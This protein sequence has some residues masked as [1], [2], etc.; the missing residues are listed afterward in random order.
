MINLNDNLESMN[1]NDLTTI[2]IPIPIPTTT[3]TTTT[4]PTT[5][6]NQSSNNLTLNFDDSSSTELSSSEALITCNN[7]LNH[8]NL[9]INSSSSC[10]NSINQ[11]IDLQ[12]ET[13]S[14]S[15]DQFNFSPISLSTNST[16]SPITP[17]FNQLYHHHHHTQN[18]P[19]NHT[20]HH[21][22]NLLSPRKFNYHS[23]CNKSSPTSSPLSIQ[24]LNLPNLSNPF[25]LNQSLSTYHPHQLNCLIPHSNI[26]TTLTTTCQVK[27]NTSITKNQLPLSNLS[28]RRRSPTA[29]DPYSLI[30]PTM[31]NFNSCSRHES[32]SS[33][34]LPSNNNHDDALSSSSS[35]FLIQPSTS[36]QSSSS[37]A[38]NPSKS[39]PFLHSSFKIHHDRSKFFLYNSRKRRSWMDYSLLALILIIVGTVVV[40]S[41][42]N[43]YFGIYPSDVILSSELEVDPIFPN[44]I[45]KIIHQTWKTSQIPERWVPVRSSCA[46]AHPDWDYMLWTDESGRNLIKE[47]YSWFLPIYDGY[48]Y[49]IQRADAVRYF[50][51]HHYGGVYM[52]L[53]IGCLRPM[54]SLLRF[55]MILPQTV[56]V[57][58]SND[59]MFS[60]KGHP[61]MNFVIHR[62]AQFDH[63]YLLNYATVMFST[64]PMA[65]SALLSQ[66]RRSTVLSSTAVMSGFGPIRILPP[67]LYGKNLAAPQPSPGPFFTHY[68]GSS[69]HTEGAGMV[70]WLGKFGMFCLYAAIAIVV[71]YSLFELF[72]RSFILGS[73]DKG[74]VKTGTTWI[75]GLGGVVKTRRAVPFLWK[76]RFSR[77]R[78]SERRTGDTV[79][80]G[81]WIDQINST[82]NQ[83]K[84]LRFTRT[85][86]A[87]RCMQCLSCKSY[88]QVSKGDEDHLP[89]YEPK[90]LHLSSCENKYTSRPDYQE[91]EVEEENW[92]QV[93]S[94]PS[95]Q[96]LTSNPTPFVLPAISTSHENSNCNNIVGNHLGTRTDETSQLP[97][98][99]LNAIYRL[100]ELAG[101]V[102][103]QSSGDE[104]IGNFSVS[105]EAGKLTNTDQVT[106]KVD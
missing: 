77:N 58:I 43:M 46:I 71:L 86:K 13:Y 54:D 28:I 19:Q 29:L 16:N 66:A 92:D 45:P 5:T 33:K 56:P 25:P 30:S 100:A 91:M 99:L 82:S 51:L 2:P 34:F 53:D 90:F 97:S 104:V 39:Q 3:T 67:H 105:L 85:Q 52:D 64:G 50:I 79:L 65:L 102:G 36:L 35:S 7:N 76:R 84:P 10:F 61:F 48:P 44:R 83:I 15:L 37:S 31:N 40:L 1:L 22:I 78:F 73:T 87:K 49:P 9:T 11:E 81:Q 23:S 101:I 12:L 55:D 95:Q 98:P 88:E 8:N 80:S 38:Y 69:W 4:I 89:A 72:R 47:H 21:Q 32:S 24:N 70:L 94:S 26:S 42:V 6:T 96:Y 62:L 106:L 14:K 63:D 17:L 68:H 20:Q 57:G 27:P 60:A 18:H 74:L 75:N 59:L 93:D 41:T 103:E